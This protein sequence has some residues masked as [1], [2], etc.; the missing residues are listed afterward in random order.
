MN[1]NIKMLLFVIILGTVTSALL[2]GMDYLT[3]DRIAANQEAEL[4]ST[5]LNAYDI[6]YTLA[7]IHDV[8][9]DSVEVIV[10]DGFRFY[11]DNETGA[12]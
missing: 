8:F 3:R 4:K 9:D 5:I 7:N 11:V 10:T 12:V 6:S 1:Q 2:L